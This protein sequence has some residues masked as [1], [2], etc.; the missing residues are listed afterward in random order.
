MADP[1]LSGLL[2]SEDEALVTDF[3]GRSS[4]VQTKGSP[5]LPVGGAPV[6]GG[7]G[8]VA[9]GGTGVST[10]PAGAT[11]GGPPSAR[12]PS[13]VP[14]LAKLGVNAAEKLQR[15]F[16][17]SGASGP[18]T[19]PTSDIL[20]D[21]PPGPPIFDVASRGTAPAPNVPPDVAAFAET[22]AEA[23]AVPATET[24]ATTGTTG[25]G[26]AEPGLAGLLAQEAGVGIN[27]GLRAQGKTPAAEQANLAAIEALMAT[28]GAGALAIP[29]TEMTLS[30]QLGGPGSPI[31]YATS[32]A[33]SLW[34]DMYGGGRYAPTRKAA[35]SG[36]TE[37]LKDFG[38]A[39]TAGAKSADPADALKGLQATGPVRADLRLPPEVA[40]Q[41]GAASF[42]D[43]KPEQFQNLLSWYAEDP[44]RIAQTIEGSGDEPYLPG[45][46]AKQV[47]DQAQSGATQLLTFL[48]N[49][50]IVQEAMQAA[51]PAAEPA[52]A[53]APTPPVTP[54]GGG[55]LGLAEIGLEVGQ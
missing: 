23:G 51:Q 22:G 54:A 28:T 18:V 31:D 10:S 33:V 46:Q 24:A 50:K 53:P 32:G 42:Q 17:G 44:S 15:M 21:A 38:N 36:A 52:P 5:T 1:L 40:Q 47:A 35:F 49:R 19:V 20:A 8:P 16:G 12:K 45:H 41:I 2:N 34:S 25:A 30:G 55:P 43:M 37:G 7:A 27:V 39:L 11:P 4:P 26:L 48:V 9:P 13:D 14:G 6:S 29:L 3:L